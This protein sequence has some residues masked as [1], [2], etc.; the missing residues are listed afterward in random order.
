MKDPLDE[1]F[2]SIFA[3]LYSV[4]I[5]FYALLFAAWVVFSD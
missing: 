1:G 5:I 3:D 2:D 4:V